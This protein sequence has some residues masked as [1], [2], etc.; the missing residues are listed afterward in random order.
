MNLD[1]LLVFLDI[2]SPA[3]LVYFEQFA[4]LM[5]EQQDIPYE[6]L[7]A[8]AEEMDGDVLSELIGGYFEDVLQSVPDDGD[9]LYTLM[10]GISTTL[11]SLAG[12][13]DTEALR[14]FAEE[15]YKFRTW[16]LIESRVY[17]TDIATGQCKEITL[18]EALTNYRVQSHTGEDFNLD[19]SE[20][21]SYQLDEYI[22]SLG[23]IIEDDYGDGDTYGEDEDYRDPAIDGLKIP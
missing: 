20:T 17:C 14:M 1:D 4:D 15:L 7:A 6:T 16:Y 11:Q 19:F 3:D 2:E 12:G 18:F 9:E 22:V 8:L 21:L 10:M 13:A 5:E 23:A